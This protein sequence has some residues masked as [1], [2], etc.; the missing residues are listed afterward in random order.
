MARRTRR[1]VTDKLWERVRPHLPARAAHLKGGRPWVDDRECL[2]GILWVLRTGR[3][4]GTSRSTFRRRRPAGGGC[5]SGPGRAA[6]TRS[7]PR[8]WPNSTSWAAWIGTS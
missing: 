3:V 4:G 1:L 2:E 7:T 8:C 5:R 6:W